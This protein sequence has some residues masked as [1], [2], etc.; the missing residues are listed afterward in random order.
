M[1]FRVYY[2]FLWMLFCRFL[3][4]I[5]NMQLSRSF[6]LQGNHPVCSIF[7]TISLTCGGGSKMI[8]NRALIRESRASL[9]TYPRLV[10]M[11]R[12]K[13]TCPCISDIS[14]SRFSIC[15][16]TF[17]PSRHAWVILHL[18]I[19]MRSHSFPFS[20][21]WV[22]KKCDFISYVKTAHLWLRT[23]DTTTTR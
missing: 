11:A 12:A 21:I 20:F 14:V 22:T 8:D 1:E 13:K 16:L 18:E 9:I 10:T 23:K 3:V 7:D 2:G 6:A 5:R 17:S 19:L 4:Q 15:K